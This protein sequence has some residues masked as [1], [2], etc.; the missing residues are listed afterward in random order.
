[1]S[2]A[3][4][5]AAVLSLVGLVV[6]FAL[7]Y[8][9]SGPEEVLQHA[10]LAIFVTLVMLLA[11]SMIMFYLI[12]KVRAI[13]DAVE[14]AGLQTDAVARAS[15][16]RPAVFKLGSVAIGLTMLTAII[17][18][19]VDTEVIPPGFHSML[20]VLALVANGIALRAVVAAFNESNRIVDEVN[21]DL[22]VE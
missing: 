9:A 13:K 21:R 19:G 22:G 12:G 16:V 4:L 20:A 11:Y 18:G 3:L 10:T 6:S 14:E 5:T 7:G 15:A 2:A 17:G 8:L 1:M